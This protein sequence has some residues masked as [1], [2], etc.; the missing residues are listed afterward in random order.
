M[1]SILIVILLIILLMIFKNSGKANANS[2]NSDDTNMNL[3]ITVDEVDP[4]KYIIVDDI[5]NTEVYETSGEG[6]TEIF[7]YDSNFN[8]DPSGELELER[9]NEEVVEELESLE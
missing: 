9:D 6:S 2:N 4:E 3:N 7:N 1:I 8:P 5:S